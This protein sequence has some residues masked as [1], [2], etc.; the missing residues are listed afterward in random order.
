MIRKKN[1]QQSEMIAVW[2]QYWNNSHSF[3]YQYQDR[4]FRAL[5]LLAIKLRDTDPNGNIIDNM[6]AFL[7]CIKGKWHLENASIYLFNSHFNQLLSNADKPLT[8][9]QIWNIN[10]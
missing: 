8:M 3:K 5:A 9:E 6:K 7:F 4:D 10:Q 1:P 2:E